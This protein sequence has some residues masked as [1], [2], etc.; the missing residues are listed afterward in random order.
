VFNSLRIALVA[1]GP[2]DEVV[3]RAVLRALLKTPFVLVR[4]QPEGSAVF[5]TLGSGWG[6]VY[7]WCKEVSKKHRHVAGSDPLL[8][9]YDALIIH[10]DA[11]VAGLR[12]EDYD[13]IPDCNDGKLPCQQPC[14]PPEKTTNALRCVLQSWCDFS[15]PHLKTVVCMPSKSSETWILAALFP[16]DKEFIHQGECLPLPENRL[17]QQPKKNR[18]RKCV[19]HYEDHERNIEASW[20]AITSKLKEAARFQSDFMTQI[21]KPSL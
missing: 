13:F 3:I 2:T 11:D 1:E 8:F 6:G 18:I 5:G 10:L 19:Q 20:S 17:K 9:N 21:L 4:L 14:P 7:R 16:Q 15:W 12:Y